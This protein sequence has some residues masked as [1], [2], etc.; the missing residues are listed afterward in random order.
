M[1]ETFRQTGWRSVDGRSYRI[2]ELTNE[3]LVNIY[4]HVRYHLDS[5]KKVAHN[6]SM[7]ITYRG[8][9]KEFVDAGPYPWKDDRGK[10]HAGNESHMPMDEFVDRI[11]LE[12]ILD[13]VDIKD[14]DASVS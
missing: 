1:A 4:H 14:P 6:I 3:H 2:H 7:E 9:S 12:K 5:Y 10:E 8:L 11:K 13:R